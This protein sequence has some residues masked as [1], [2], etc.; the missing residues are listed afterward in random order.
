LLTPFSLFMAP[1][2]ILVFYAQQQHTK[3]ISLL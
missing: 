3:L 2:Q 1:S